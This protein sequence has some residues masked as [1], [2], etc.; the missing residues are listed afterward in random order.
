MGLHAHYSMPPTA[1]NPPL[2]S[3]RSN[4]NVVILP[5]AEILVLGGND[6]SGAPPLPAELL[7]AA[8]WILGPLPQS[9]HDYH[10][11]GLLLPS[12]R[13]LLGGGETRHHPLPSD[14]WDYEIFEPWYITAP[15]RP[16]I[17]TYP[18]GPLQYNLTYTVGH[19][20][21]PSPLVN[22]AKVVLTRP[23]TCTHGFDM[24]QRYVDLQVLGVSRTSVTFKAPPNARRAPQGWYMLWLVSDEKVPSEA[25]WVQ[26]L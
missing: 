5:S 9:A 15:N 11:F 23:G 13:V 10:S 3:G 21:I 2:N 14:G 19:S 12:G 7:S 20:E 22:V 6:S 24:G 4:I 26:I 1:L 17:L 25:V 18:S 16:T 8:T